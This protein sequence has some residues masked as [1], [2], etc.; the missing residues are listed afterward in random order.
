M[1]RALKLT[2]RKRAA[3]VDAAIACFHEHGFDRASMDLIAREARVSKRT[4][5][6]HFSSKELLFDEIVR[7][8]KE[9]AG[10]AVALIYAPDAAPLPQLLHFCRS[11]VDFH[12]TADSRKLIRILVSKFLKAPEL[13]KA[14]FGN[15]KMFEDCLTVWIREAQRDLVIAAC[16]PPFAAKQLLAMLESF[17]VWPQLIKKA[18]VPNGAQR[19]RIAKSAAE[20]FLAYY[21]MEKARSRPQARGPKLPL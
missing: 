14:T 19:H 7:R 8:L 13:A 11:V 4:I 18:A 9:N 16:D 17:V 1:K 10:A 6:N 3:I 5:Y 21:A 2:D 15:A 12:C 20:M